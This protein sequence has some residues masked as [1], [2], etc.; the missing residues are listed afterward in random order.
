MF[1]PLGTS[2]GDRVGDVV[3][4]EVASGRGVRSASMYKAQREV[5]L[6]E[7]PSPGGCWR[8]S[9]STNT[10]RSRKSNFAYSHQSEANEMEG[11]AQ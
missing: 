2:T 1:S 3:Q 6:L 5:Q 7:Y 8:T 10:E 9:Q 4:Y 11:P